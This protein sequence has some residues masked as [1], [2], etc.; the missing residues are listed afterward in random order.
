M[1]VANLL[2]VFFPES[3]IKKMLVFLSALVVDVAEVVA[4]FLVDD[5]VCAVLEL[6]EQGVG[7]ALS[8]DFLYFCLWGD[9]VV[10]CE[11]QRVL[12]EGDAVECQFA[13]YRRWAV[14]LREL[15]SLAIGSILKG[16]CA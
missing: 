3:D 9:G 12:V 15:L 6:S 14:L 2:V 1:E 16:F 7:S 4:G 8:V 11:R 5:V 13:C 10:G